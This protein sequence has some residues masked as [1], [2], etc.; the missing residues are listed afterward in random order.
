LQRPSKLIAAA[1]LTLASVSLSVPQ[2]ALA[3]PPAESPVTV[4]V[5]IRAPFTSSSSP[6]SLWTVEL[7]GRYPFSKDFKIPYA[8]LESEIDR[9][10]DE[11]VPNNV[12][13]TEVC[14]DPCPDVE[15]RIKLDPKFRFT[16]KGQPKLTQIG[17]SGQSKV[18]VEL[19]TEA[20]LDLHAD[21]TA[22]TWLDAV[23]V[24]VDVFV[25]VGMKASVDISLWPDLVA[26]QPGS[27]KSGVKLEFELVDTD[28]EFDLNGTAVELGFKWGTIIGFTPLGLLAGGPILG[29]VLAIFGDAAA[30]AAEAKINREF[31]KQVGKM[32]DQ[33][34][35]ELGKIA[36]D[37][38]DPYITQANDLKDGLLDTPIPGVGKT[39][40]GLKS[41]LGADIQLHTVA[42]TSSVSSAA[43]LR[44]SGAAAG[45]KVLGKVRLP[46]EVCEYASFSV[47]GV[48]GTLPLG[49]AP[50]NQDLDAKVG[51]NCSA[52]L[53]ETFAR[54]LFR[55][56]NPRAA[57][58]AA[59]E[60]LPTWSGTAGSLAY[61]GKVRETND[62]YEC[63]FELTGLPK[64]AILELSADALEA[65]GI[66]LQNR[67][68]AVLA[69]G[70]SRVFDDK[71]APLPEGTGGNSSLVL[72]G[73][74]KCGG[75]SSGGGLTPNKMKALKDSLDPAKCPQCGLAKQP[76]SFVYEP[77]DMK[78][79]LATPIVKEV[80]A[81]V[82]QN[83]AKVKNPVAKP[84]AA[85]PGA[86]KP[87]AVNPGAVNPGAANGH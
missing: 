9:L 21:V 58:G 67:F 37:Y 4:S 86:A 74:G 12:Y 10:I 22:E 38:I 51:N 29:P 47:G 1:A 14:T 27:S 70:K 66:S 20:R 69:A 26:K 39:I 50:A 65:R 48:S 78:A 52:V 40:E 60:D 18:R 63:D 87:G 77:A 75:G 81:R 8:T 6:K 85:K 41:D 79:L 23:E 62:W 43:I 84:G 32:F 33:Q 17:S 28:L 45:G 73:K 59:A 11:Q 13:G 83:K 7:D 54:K 34:T 5:Q 30:D 56:A 80:L 42:T 68:M 19:E 49:L 46:K 3:A 76:G 35:K 64:A 72:G 57:L 55:G 53:T 2:V 25:V 82:K 15:W 71:L 44:M 24:P 36:N 16:K 31:E 61:V